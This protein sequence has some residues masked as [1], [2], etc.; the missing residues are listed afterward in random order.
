MIA[1]QDLATGNKRKLAEALG[2]IERRAGEADVVALLDEAYATPK[3][4]VIG[5]TGPP[6]VGKST[7]ISA[8]IGHWRRAGLTVGV[9]AVDPSSKI[10]GGALLGDRAR[11]TSDPADQ[12]IFIRS[13]A[14]RG[15]LGG[16]ADIAFA[17]IVLMR[18]VFDR[19]LVES[20]GVGQSEA[21]IV[22]VA[23]TVVLCIQP[24]S[25]DALQFMKSGIMEIPAIAVV[26]KADMGAAADRA[27]A[28]LKSAMM[29]AAPAA[30]DIP[31]LALAATSGQGIDELDAALDRHAAF[32]AK[33]GELAAGRGAQAKAWIESA[34]KAE[35]GARGVDLVRDELARRAEAPFR[36]QQALLARL[37]VRLRPRV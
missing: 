17:S 35:A 32:L 22:A 21:E 37:E 4:S 13:L 5:I 14:A 3:G 31:V 20:V 7:L 16:L 25:G 1:L 30:W 12:G 28:D 24:G 11:M 8:L 29:L 18:A 27:V 34:V 6:G 26:T 2:D 10:S 36:L 9:I 15:R 19:V 23:D 33:T